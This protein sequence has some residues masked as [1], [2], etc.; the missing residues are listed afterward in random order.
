MA[1]AHVAY[2]H[3]YPVKGFS[4]EALESVGLITGRPFPGD[5]LYAV[6]NG[7]SG[8]DPAAPGFQPKVKYFE[9]MRNPR[10]GALATRYDAETRVMRIAHAGKTLAEGDLGAAEGRA[11]I[12]DCVAAFMAGDLRGPARVLAGT[13]GYQFMDSPSSGAVSLLG[14]ASVRD[15]A[16][17]A[18]RRALD[19]GRFRMNFGLDGLPPW[20]ELD[21]VGRTV[22]LG[23]A[24]LRIVKRTERCSAI[25][26]PPGQG[27]RDTRLIQ[28]MEEA[29][30]HHDCGVYAKVV[31]GGTVRV[32][33]ALE[34]EQGV[35]L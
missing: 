27:G 3:R 7:P 26:V 31:E 16:A 4:A 19:P 2:I 30:S 17:R 5:R 8:Y 20:G 22:R 25:D 15:L 1:D 33:D 29:F 35:L 11:A 13:Q 18:G 6:E 14:L 12:E 21:L 34:I 24:R 23:A 10:L 32:G 9:L 28:T